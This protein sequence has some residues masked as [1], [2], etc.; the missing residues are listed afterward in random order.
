M[1]RD[2]L[3]AIEPIFSPEF[4]KAIQD[5]VL[6]AEAPSSQMVRAMAAI[7]RN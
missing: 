5:K 3:G 7:G 6:A 4:Q 2:A 1:D